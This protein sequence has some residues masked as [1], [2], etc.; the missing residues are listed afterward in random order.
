MPYG[1]TGNVL[2]AN[3]TA[4]TVTI[5]RHDDAYYRKFMGGAALAMDYILRDVPAYADPLG[6]EN[7]LVFA[8]GPLTGT[9]ISGQSRMSVNAKSP[10]TGVIGDAQVGGF[11]PAEL[12]FA[13]FDAVVVKGA[14]DKPVYLYIKDGVA[15]IRDASTYWGMGTGEL[16]DAME[17]DLGDDKIQLMAIGPAGE[18][19]V[20]Y[21][22]TVNMASRAAGR[23]GMGAVQGSKKLKAIVCRGTGKVAVK[24]PAALKALTQW[25]AK[26]VRVNLAMAGL[27]KYGTAET[28]LAQ[29]AVGGLPTRNWESGVFD[30]A[31]E[32]SGERMYDTILL[33]NDTCYACAVRCKRVVQE[34]N[35]GVEGRYGGP[36]YE[37]LA[38]L[39]SYCMVDDLVAIALANQLCNIHGMDPIAVGATIAWAMDAFTKGIIDGGDTGGLEIEWGDAEMML[40]LTEL[41]A[42]REGFGDVLA[43]GMRG[44][45]DR[46]G[47]G[48]DELTEVKGN[49]LPAHMPQVKKSLAL[50]YAVNPFGADHQ[51]H[52]HDPG[53]TPDADEES[54]RRMALLGLDDPQDA[55][56]LS[57]EKVR[58]ALI[59]QQFYSLLDSASVCQFVYGPSWQLYGPDHL[60]DALNAATGW[61]V[62]V[63]E[64]VEVGA[65][66][67]TMQ[68][69]FNARDGIG[70]NEDKLPKKLFKGLSGG[71]SDGYKVGQ[72]EFARGLDK[73][74]ELAGWDGEAGMPTV[75]ALDR[76]GLAGYA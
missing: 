70:R 57:D 74:Y 46:L 43:E 33:K 49:A 6:P 52:E 23:T 68:R 12:K 73:Y 39:G 28:V 21:A 31:E 30:R 61:D 69:Y 16:Q 50:I 3:L 62:T 9:P 66:K 25:G 32:I 5:D 58:F 4:G 56:N 72:E 44:A 27:Q 71:P 36:E 76:Y 8:V 75:A 22:C 60:R 67:L 26:N 35:R 34:E 40:H 29:Q 13:G 10:L 55:L 20:K 17:A 65:R 54:L 42:R 63:D 38:T 47:K 64:L 45:A 48:H 7:V 19:L 24:D 11:F 15:E 59:T 1:Y 51:S 53:Y 18:N 41:I 2:V 37:N 14:S